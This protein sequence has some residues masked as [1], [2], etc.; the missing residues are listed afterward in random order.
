MR[1][2][3]NRAVA[4][5]LFLLLSLAPQAE[6]AITEVGAGTQR[7]E[8]PVDE[9]PATIAFPGNVTAGNLLV[10]ACMTNDAGST[11]PIA[12]PTITDTVLSTYTIVMGHDQGGSNDYSTLIAY[13]LAASSGANT[14][15]VTMDA[16]DFASCAI[17]EFTGVAASPSDA[18]G[19]G[20]GGT[21]T[22]S[23]DSITTVAANAL[24]IGISGSNSDV[25]ITPEA[26]WTEIHEHEPD[27]IFNMTFRIVTTADAY[28]DTWTLG[29]SVQW[30]AQ[31]HSFKPLVA[32]GAKNM[33][34]SGVGEQ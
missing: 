9:T 29:S 21:S 17:D 22:T 8:S 13:A 12:T 6:A 10:V 25:A 19:G 23:V 7:A 27:I 24:I 32:G 14:I 1:W 30:W 20:A 15:T 34:M 26:D 3:R 4:L 28:A 5:G 16:G 18:A 31:T 2:H 33:P 11:D